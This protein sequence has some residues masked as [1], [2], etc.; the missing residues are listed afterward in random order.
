MGFQ[1]APPAL[2]VESA[3]KGQLAGVPAVAGTAK[4]PKR[5]A[6]S[7]AL[8]QQQQQQQ[9]QVMMAMHMQPMC[10]FSQLQAQMG[11]DMRHMSMMPHMHGY[12]ATATPFAN[13]GPPAGPPMQGAWPPQMPGMGFLPPGVSMRMDSGIGTETCVDPMMWHAHAPG[14][15]ALG[16]EA[17]EGGAHPMSME[18]MQYQFPE[19]SGDA[20]HAFSKPQPSCSGTTMG[21]LSELLG[22]PEHNSVAL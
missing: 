20:A 19:A 15:P 11:V 21:L 2:L 1:G 14:A 13:F 12:P 16:A 6:S 22:K 17:G 9:Q 8:Q 3:V 7:K 18:V 4:P 10:D 5:Q